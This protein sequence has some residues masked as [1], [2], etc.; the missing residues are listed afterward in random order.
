MSTKKPEEP[1]ED[2]SRGMLDDAASLDQQVCRLGAHRVVVE[3]PGG[4]VRAVLLL[5]EHLAADVGTEAVG[6]VAARVQAHAEQPLVAELAP[7]L[8]PVGLAQLVDVLRAE[9]LEGGRLDPVGEDRPEGDE[10]GV[11][12]RMRLCVGVLGT[13]KLAGVLRGER[14]HGVDVLA[15]GVEAV[16][17]RALGVL[18]GEPGAHGEQDGRGGV[19]LRR[20]QL[21]RGAL[22]SQLLTCGLRHTRLDRRDHLQRPVVGLGGLVSL[23]RSGGDGGARGHDAQT[24]ARDRV[25]PTSGRSQIADRRLIA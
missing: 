21:E 2:E 7:Q 4:R 14:F 22:V 10:V 12:A 25:R 13:E 1:A 3:Q 5:V 19:V 18:V 6:Q 24:M 23:G 9:L 15:A 20:D 11:D 8:L 16:P 17:D